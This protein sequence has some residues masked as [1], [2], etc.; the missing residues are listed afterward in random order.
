MFRQVVDQRFGI[1]I[2]GTAQRL[3][4][5]EHDGFD[6]I[7]SRRQPVAAVDGGQVE[8]DGHLTGGDA[9]IVPGRKRLFETTVGLAGDLALGDD[10]GDGVG[11]DGDLPFLPARAVN[12]DLAGAGDD[13]I[14]RRV[15]G[16][17]HFGAARDGFRQDQ[18]A[19]FAVQPQL[20]AAAG[21]QGQGVGGDVVQIQ[22]RLAGVGGRLRPAF[23][24]WPGLGQADA[25]GGE[26]ADRR[27]P[28]ERAEHQRYHQHGQ[29]H[30]A[31]RERVA[32]GEAQVRLDGAGF[33]GAGGHA[34]AVRGPQCHRR[35]VGGAGG[36]LVA[37]RRDGL[38]GQGRVEPGHR[39][40]P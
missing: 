32:G 33:G 16:G 25:A 24:A 31:Q 4:Q 23:P 38:A 3:R 6:R 14:L 1:G 9:V 20:D 5:V 36:L 28:P 12:G 2:A 39:V 10:G 21:G 19:G 40:E 34:F 35:G 22:R 18:R 7:G 29:R 11:Q 8:A 17:R 13:E 30:I 26:R 27:H 15:R 37:Q